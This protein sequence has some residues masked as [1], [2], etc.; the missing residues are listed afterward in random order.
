MA[1]ELRS[2]DVRDANE[3]KRF[4]CEECRAVEGTELFDG[5]LLCQ[6]CAWA[7]LAKVMKEAG[8]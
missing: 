2:I 4:P 7:A 8:W 5:R 1:A 6:P 3:A